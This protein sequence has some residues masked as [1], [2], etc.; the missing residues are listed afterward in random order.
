MSDTATRPAADS[1]AVR[2]NLVETL[3]IDLIGP[4]PS[5]TALQR[6]RLRQAPSR[7]YLTGFLV[8]TDAP[9][10]QRAKTRKR[11]STSRPSRF[12]E[13]TIPTLPTGGAGSGTTGPRRWV[14]ASW[15]T[16]RRGTWR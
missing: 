4:R 5:D 10:E 13:A 15:W 1:G 2:D 3:R 9:L 7:W 6:E 14:L 11:S 8:P 16:R 12:T